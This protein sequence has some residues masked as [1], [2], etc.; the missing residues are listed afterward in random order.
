MFTFSQASKKLQRIFKK[1]FGA[2]N[3]EDTYSN[4]LLALEGKSER[5]LSAARL[6]I[7][8]LPELLSNFETAIEQSEKRVDLANRSLEISS[9]ELTERNT[10]LFALTQ[11]FTTIMDSLEQALFLFDKSG[12]CLP[13]YSK[14]C[15][16]IFK[17]KPSGK[18]FNEVLN[19]RKS[20][21][22]SMQDWLDLVFSEKIKFEDLI[23]L[24]P[25]SSESEHLKN[26]EVEFKAIRNLENTIEGVLVIATDKTK[27]IK[28]KNEAKQNFVF[29]Q[30]VIKLVSDTE[31]YINFK[32]QVNDCVQWL[33]TL[34]SSSSKEDASIGAR[35]LHDIKGICSMFHADALRASIH[36]CESELVLNYSQFI[37]SAQ[38]Y[39]S[40]ISNELAIYENE[41]AKVFGESFFKKDSFRWVSNDQ[42]S[43]L[44]NLFNSGASLE[45][46]RQQF[47]SCFLQVNL[48]DK[49]K[50]FVHLTQTLAANLKKKL[51]PL[52]LEI[53]A[54][55]KVSNSKFNPFCDTLFHIF[56]NMVDHAIETT[57]VRAAFGKGEF[58][59]I[60]LTAKMEMMDQ[61]KYLVMRFSDDGRGISGEDIRER[62]IHRGMH[63]EDAQKLSIGDL[64]LQIFS[65][66]F[67]TA[68]HVSQYS[69][70]GIGLSSV[71]RELDRLGGRVQVNSKEGLG[72][73]FTFLI[74][75]RS[76]S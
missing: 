65:E 16:K 67:S 24:L 35:K 41:M 68:E 51:A 30:K 52:S 63:K 22:S 6:L 13:V 15:E 54:D 56:T 71:K 4:A 33:T 73:T 10:T 49:C 72:T 3:I 28:A 26:V 23:A 57:E 5:D 17:C 20:E 8:N 70:R 14:S 45:T 61:E 29:S 18:R 75:M 7:K 9:K 36:D 59:S 46:I 34:N 66:G 76:I 19:F 31:S 74:P 39:I 43:E 38:D 32:K 27:E 60:S 48:L 42:I 2:E 50:P 44:N 37:E 69:G 11:E 25:A 53:E 1:I 47:E 55:I 12:I 58:A 40:R 64:Y 21:F 62:L